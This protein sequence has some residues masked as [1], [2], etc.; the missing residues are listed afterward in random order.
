V[1]AIGD[2]RPPATHRIDHSYAQDITAFGQSVGRLQ[3]ASEKTT[4]PAI[5]VLQKQICLIQRSAPFIATNKNVRLFLGLTNK[6]TFYRLLV[7]LT[8]RANRMRY[9]FGPKRSFAS[10]TRQF[11]ETQ[12][13]SVPKRKLTCKD[14]FVLT[15]M[16]L[17]L[18][19]TTNFLATLFGITSG[20]A[21]TLFI[22][23]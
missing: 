18:G 6:A 13:K 2:E 20:L 4:L 11:C 8:P 1:R 14:E 23:G 17:K 3:S 5:A 10:H 15:L 9:W 16:K 7:L 22:R 21:Q 12:T 19:L